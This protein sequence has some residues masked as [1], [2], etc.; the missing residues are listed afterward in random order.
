M[1]DTTGAPP[2]PPTPAPAGVAGGD[3]AKA[4]D[5]FQLPPNRIN[6]PKAHP[7]LKAAGVNPN[8]PMPAEIGASPADAWQPPRLRTT[9]P[10]SAYKYQ[11]RGGF[12]LFYDMTRLPVVI[13]G[14]IWAAIYVK[15]SIL[16]LVYGPPDP[17]ILSVYHDY[18][19]KRPGEWPPYKPER[20]PSLPQGGPRSYGIRH[21]VDG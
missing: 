14:G 10:L 5:D 4:L 18:D 13:F 7:R 2:P 16:D 11:Y 15:H 1:A 20:D 19:R 21:V 9:V 6:P 3:L 8:P 17:K 12:K